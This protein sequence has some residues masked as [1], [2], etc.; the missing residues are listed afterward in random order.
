MI[1]SPDPII[2]SFRREVTIK[3]PEVLVYNTIL[4]LKAIEMCNIN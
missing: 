4:Y 2:P 3:K 1:I